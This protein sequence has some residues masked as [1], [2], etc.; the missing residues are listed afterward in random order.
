M[1][2]DSELTILLALKDRTPFTFRWLSYVDHIRFPFEVCIADGGL[3]DSLQPAL[4]DTA[5]FPHVKY[6]YVRY[7]PDR[8]YADY[9]AK[10]DDALSRI[11]TPFVALA[12][13]DDFFAVDG[14]R[15]AVDF[16]RDHPDYA[17]CGGHCAVFWLNPSQARHREEEPSGKHIEW[18]CS[19]DAQ[20][21]SGDTA[22]DRVWNLPRKSPQTFHYH[23]R[24]TEELR[25]LFHVLKESNLKDI[26]LTDQLLAFL[27]AISGKTQ[28]LDTLYL[29]RQ[30]D[31]SGG[32]ADTHRAAFGDW[33]GRMLV[34]S[35][36]DDFTTFLNVTSTALAEQDRISRDEARRCV[37][38][39]YRMEL[40]PMLLADVSAER[41]VTMPM[42]IV[43]RL[44]R[45]LLALS[46]ESPSRRIAR[47]LYRRVRWISTD[48]VHGTQLRSRPVPD[49]AREI[50]PIHA[51][52]TR[53]PLPARV[54]TLAPDHE[55]TILL[56][57][58]DRA[59][60]TFRW[61][62]YADSIRFPFNVLIADGSSDDRAASVLSSHTAFPSVHYQYVRYAPDRSYCADYWAK[63]ADALA[64]IRSPYVALADDDDLFVVSGLSKAVRF[65]ADHPDY[66]TCGGQCAVF[67]VTPSQQDGD[68]RLCYGKHL[69]W[70]CSLDA[71][72][73]DDDTARNRIRHHSLRATHPVYYHVRR[74][75]E[76][77]RHVDIV[78]TLD[79]KDPFLIERLL[80][81]LAAIAG[82]TQQLDTLYIARQWNAPGSAG[83]AHQAQHGDW[84]GRMLLPSWSQDFNNLLRVISAA[85][86]ERDGIEIG[87]AQQSVITLCRMWLAPQLLGDLAREPTVT[88]RM[89]MVAWIVRRVLQRRPDSR[90]RRV[91]RAF[92]RRNRWISLEAVHG[93]ELRA[94]HTSDVEHAFKPIHEFLAGRSESV[95]L[96]SLL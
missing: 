14:L 28:Q 35:W 46:P 40:A 81:L 79:L 10:M 17:A 70:K 89:S 13:N 42:A 2:P 63:V 21:L 5:T 84:L 30:W 90:I 88:M 37:I 1:T 23:V 12:D 82:K 94:T 49:A 15:E 26:F 24:R 59:P 32:A 69:E 45:R 58:K 85:L 80:F 56:A 87:E 73:L 41:T 3:D 6:E 27:T 20:S 38:E 55:L 29:A 4:S 31:S 16:L 93:T 36:S 66:A 71:R 64:R 95:G 44:V 77:K 83:A 51:F 8:S 78:R 92:Y 7:P 60:F 57:L 47:A 52:L 9:Y 67:W 25:T 72:S 96:H 22:R 19:S 76:L 54:P 68:E 61:L 48:A 18:K 91:A 86:A 74:T 33:L 62:A 39:A 43:V 50:K 75:E 53:Q 65:L 34:P 11:R